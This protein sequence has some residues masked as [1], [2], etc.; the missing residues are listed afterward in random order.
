M[1]LRPATSEDASALARI[2]G[3]WVRETGWMPV[4]H[5]R[6]EDLGLV[7]LMIEGMEVTIAEEGEPLG[8]LTLDGDQAQAFQ[9]AREARGSGG[10][11]AL[12]DHARS[13]RRHLALWVFEANARAVA[14]YACEGFRVAQRTDGL[15]NEEG[16]PDLRMIWDATA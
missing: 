5:T 16:L 15:H 1:R 4:L 13:Q 2:W 11:R 3:D 8:F 14:F 12:L 9:V 10:G 6:E 7:R